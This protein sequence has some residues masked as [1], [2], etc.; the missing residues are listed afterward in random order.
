[1]PADIEALAAL[2]VNLVDGVVA[3]D[4]REVELNPVLV[5]RHG[6]VAVDALWFDATRAARPLDKE[7][8]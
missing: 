3:S 6:A 8:P 2:V 7:G 5:G 4:A 1:M